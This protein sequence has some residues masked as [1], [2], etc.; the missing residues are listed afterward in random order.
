MVLSAV[1]WVISAANLYADPV[2]DGVI[3]VNGDFQRWD[4]DKP[5]DWTIPTGVTVARNDRNDISLSNNSNERQYVNQS[6]PGVQLALQAG[7]ML[8]WSAEIMA[9]E[10]SS[11]TV[12]IWVRYENE[13]LGKREIAVPVPADG[14]WTSIRCVL[15]IEEIPVKHV[16]FLIGL[17]T[18]GSAC[19]VRR[20]EGRVLPA[21]E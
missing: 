19:V 13:S 10:K 16:W 14:K 2:L 21:F 1:L 6:Y 8:W 5:A 4:G 7:D 12:E 3:V 9:M 15:P 18:P 20:V 11:V 17:K